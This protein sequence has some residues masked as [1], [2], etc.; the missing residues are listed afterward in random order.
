MRAL[1]LGAPAGNDVWGAVAWSVGLTVVFAYLAV[2]RYRR[3]V[4]R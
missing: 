1:F 4:T 3:A 2:N